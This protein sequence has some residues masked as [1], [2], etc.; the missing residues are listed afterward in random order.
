MP[1]RSKSILLVTLQFVFI[2]ILLS[3]SRL[4][5]FQVL[6]STF[7]IL[8]LLLMLWAVITMQKSK[9]RILPEPSLHAV[10]ITDG[11]YRF[12][13]HPM[14]TAILLGSL[15]LLTHQFTWIR[16]AIAIALTIVLLIKLSWEEKMLSWK[17]EGYGQY[18]KKTYRLIPFVF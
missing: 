8:S 3:G 16:L 7:I 15:G 4:N 17:F 2:L 14:Y 9:L 6:A 1:N 5:N 11:P 13:R 12:V 10:L 18:A